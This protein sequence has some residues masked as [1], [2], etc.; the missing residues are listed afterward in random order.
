MRT[1]TSLMNW[2][3]TIQQCTNK[4]CGYLS[5]INSTNQSCMTEEDKVYLI[6]KFVLV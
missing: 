3:L 4:F 2:W 5:Q 6:K 1:Q